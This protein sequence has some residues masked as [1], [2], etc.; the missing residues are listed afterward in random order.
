MKLRLLDGTPS[1]AVLD[2]WHLLEATALHDP[3]GLAEALDAA[4]DLDVS[5]AFAALAPAAAFGFAVVSST[6]RPLLSDARFE[7]WFGAPDEHPAFSRLTALARREGQASGLVD[8][9]DGQM[10]AGCAGTA[11]RA[12]AWPL[13]L[14]VRAAATDGEGRVV[15]MGFAPSRDSALAET[16]TQTLGL[17]PLEAR[18]AEAL[19]DSASVRIAAERIGVGYETAREALSKIK[20]RLGAPRTSDVVRRMV[21]LMCGDLS[22]E[23]DL[24]P[25]LAASLGA[26]PAEARV[27]AL[28]AQGLSAAEIAVRLGVRETTVRGQIKS[29]YAKGGL[30]K[31]RDLVRIASEVGALASIT[32]AAEVAAQP[33]SVTGRLRVIPGPDGRQLAF[34]DYGPRG[35]RPLLV[36]HGT[37]TG[38]TLPPPIVSALHRAGWRPIVPQRPGFGLTEAATGDYEATAG[39]DMAA[40]LG[41][42]K[43]SAAWVLARDDSVMAALAFA[44][45]HPDRVRGGVL[46]NPRLPGQTVRSPD[47]LMGG[48]TRAF[49]ARPEMV[50]A[51]A[52]MLRRQ[53]RTDLMREMVRKSASE[54]AADR[55][56]LDQ[57]GVLGSIV[58][59]IQAMAAR[60]SRGFAMEQ[61]LYAR[62]WG[63]PEECGGDHWSLIELEPLA[64]QATAEAFGGVPISRTETLPE[65]GLLAYHSHPDEVAALATRLLM[66]KGAA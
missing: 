54:V 50:G 43:I 47:T 8:A 58:R 49:L 35:G 61:S 44:S 62:G 39:D 11:A 48:V 28:A 41:A 56:I 65:A 64:R 7:A 33:V 45:R 42:L 46:L 4:A 36:G 16:A 66:Q 5:H 19:L 14:E 15:L 22:V 59:D 60:S 21:S 32:E 34:W 29:L 23:P 57:P 2:L 31:D 38:R 20:K 17:S 51:F 24:A 13:P 37:I 1:R 3:E 63:P 26:T 52:E 30:G 25:V 53:T 40:M 55:E 9:E 6:G 27:G 10:L 12:A 18:L